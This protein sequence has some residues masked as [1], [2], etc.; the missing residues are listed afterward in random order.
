M[1]SLE[2]VHVVDNYTDYTPYFMGVILFNILYDIMRNILCRY[3]RVIYPVC[4]VL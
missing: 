1:Y 2:V 3:Q 4:L